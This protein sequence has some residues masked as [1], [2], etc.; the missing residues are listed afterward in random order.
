MYRCGLEV[1]GHDH[2]L[3]HSST[4]HLPQRWDVCDELYNLEANPPETVH[5]LQTLD[6]SSSELRVAR[7]AGVA[8]HDH[9]RVVAAPA[10]ASSVGIGDASSHR[11]VDVGR[12]PRRP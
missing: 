6:E 4:R 8:G 3:K 7:L 11:A 10:C 1:L 9:R 5:V 12:C 2:R